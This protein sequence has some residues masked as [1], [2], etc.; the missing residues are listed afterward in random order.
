MLSPVS[1]RTPVNAHV[2][3]VLGGG[4]IVFVDEGRL[5]GLEYYAAEDRTPTKFP[6]VAQIRPY[7]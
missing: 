3:G 2:E 6:D 4:L 7:A 5:T 1:R